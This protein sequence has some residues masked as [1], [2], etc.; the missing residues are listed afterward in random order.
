MQKQSESHARVIIFSI[1]LFCIL[2]SVYNLT[3]SGTYITDDEHIL[4]SRTISLAYDHAINDYRVLGNSRIY[5][6]SSLEPIYASQG[7]NIEPVQAI[8]GVLLAK[9]AL[10]FGFGHIQ[11]IYLLNIVITA[12]TAVILFWTLY[13]LGYSKKTSF[14]LGILFGICTIAWPYT[15]TYF[16]DSIAM[17]FLSLAW[18]AYL[19]ITSEQ[20]KYHRNNKLL[21]TYWLILIL[22]LWL[23]ILSKNSVF[24]AVPV[25]I[26]S[27]LFS[28]IRRMK[29]NPT[30]Q[31]P[32]MV[33]GKIFLGFV[34]FILLILLWLIIGTSSE[35][36]SR[37]TFNYYQSVF[38]NFLN[39]PHPQLFDAL[40][41]PIFSPGKSIFI[42]SPILLLSLISLFKFFRHAW[43]EWFFF[44]T[45][46]IG[47]ALFYDA[48]WWGHVNWGLR[49][50]IPTIP[51]LVLASAP[52]VDLLLTSLKGQRRLLYLGS[53]SFVVQ[54]VGILA[55][56]RQYYIALASS[57]PPVSVATAIWDPKYTAWWWH[58]KWIIS[59]GI[60]DL[61]ISRVGFWS[62][63]LIII[64]VFL[65]S[66]SIILI[67]GKNHP[68]IALVILI[69]SIISSG[70][71]LSIFRFDPAN[72][73]RNDLVQTESIIRELY[74]DKDIII[75]K[76]YG[77]M[78]WSYWMNWAVPELKW[79]SLPYYFPDPYLKEKYLIIGDTTDEPKLIS[80]DIIQKAE[81]D[82]QRVWIVLPEDSPGGNFNWEATY[83]GE[84]NRLISYW[85]IS[86]DENSTRL[87]LFETKN[88]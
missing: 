35:I 39:N 38:I 86:G 36:F 20:S 11:S 65:I 47:Q 84:K 46:V 77:T 45:L 78:A 3:Y 10:F 61:A 34:L 2:V 13:L 85:F 30:Q 60:S 52:L 71:M 57:I 67:N 87:Y 49:F 76:S 62:L 23:G 5:S 4:A 7:L 22:G 33:W 21:I 80:R 17:F 25:I 40:M 66:C 12:F 70:I 32:K 1:S 56:I 42:Y 69:V 50:L 31:N 44:L 15:R 19:L 73:T 18:G 88:D 26:L 9:P 8:L 6:Y 79:I 83:L 43:S 63:P 48:D 54:I 58:L 81:M 64:S 82:Y 55:P 27:F 14:I 68:R 53:V 41:G 37:F 51:L 16:R 59:G 72:R 28:L 24:F 74:Q 75:I 29:L